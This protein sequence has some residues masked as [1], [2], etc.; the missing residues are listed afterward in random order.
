MSHIRVGDK[1]RVTRKWTEKRAD[2]TPIRPED[3]LDDDDEA[4]ET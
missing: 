3:K 1:V 4:T 2:G